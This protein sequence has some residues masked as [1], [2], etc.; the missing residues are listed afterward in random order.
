MY[1]Y[2]YLKFMKL[3]KC[4]MNIWYQMECMKMEMPENVYGPRFY[5]VN[6]RFY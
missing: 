4:N 1:K 5:R 3:H 6:P 2:V